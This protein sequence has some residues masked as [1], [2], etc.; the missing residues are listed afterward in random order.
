MKVDL[1]VFGL[2]NILRALESAKGSWDED[3]RRLARAPT[4]IR[5]HSYGSSGFW[6]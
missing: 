2:R 4:K 3:G 5:E 6:M 1:R